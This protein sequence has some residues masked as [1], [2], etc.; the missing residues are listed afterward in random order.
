[1]PID[2]WETATIVIPSF[3][4]AIRSGSTLRI[5]ITTPGRDHGT[6]EFESPVYDDT[7]T[8]QLGYGELYPSKLSL[9]TLEGIAVPESQPPCP[10]L[11]GQPCRIY[12]DT[13]NMSA[14]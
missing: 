3:A 8:F 10:S 2:E 9:R 13:P 1:M 7:P 5:S 11:R 4:H 12:V 14:E 6:W